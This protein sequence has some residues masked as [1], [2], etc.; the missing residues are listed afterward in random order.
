[1][2]SRRGGSG[3]EGAGQRR[4]LTEREARLRACRPRQPTGW[5]RGAGLVRGEGRGVSD[6]YGVRDAACP[7]STRGGR[8]GG[9][10]VCAGNS[11]APARCGRAASSSSSYSEGFSCCQQRKC[12]VG[13]WVGATV[14]E[15]GGLRRR[16]MSDVTVSRARPRPAGR[17]PAPSDAGRAPPPSLPY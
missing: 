11:G 3:R 1:V 10:P 8:G 7:L 5:H 4:E 12:T 17:V 13:I 2:G 15:G 9:A 6:W 16:G 14:G